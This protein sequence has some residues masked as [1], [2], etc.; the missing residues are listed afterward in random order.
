MPA[1]LEA[2]P[3]RVV[4]GTNMPINH[5]QMEIERIRVAAIPETA[6]QQ[7]LGSNMARI[8]GLL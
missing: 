8:L 5:P 3:E 1:V 7:I 6:R 2:S 4:F